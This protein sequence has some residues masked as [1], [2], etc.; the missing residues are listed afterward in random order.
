MPNLTLIDG[1][2]YDADGRRYCRRCRELIS[3]VG[4]DDGP[5][6]YTCACTL[7]GGIWVPPERLDI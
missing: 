5:A 4:S 3:D 7:V 2:L 6:E 1:A